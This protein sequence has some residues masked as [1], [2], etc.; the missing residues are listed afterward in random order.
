[1]KK[2]FILFASLTLG[3]LVASCQN[4]LE[5]VINESAVQDELASTR[6]DEDSSDDEEIP[7]R[8]P[9]GPAISGPKIITGTN[10]YIYSVDRPSINDTILW[11]Y[12]TSYFNRII[13]DTIPDTT[14]RLTLKN[15]NIA[16]DATIIANFHS[17]GTYISHQSR[18][19]IGINGP[20]YNHCSIRVVR[21]SDGAEIYP[22][23]TVYMEPNTNY[24]A[25]FS[26]TTGGSNMNL[27]WTFYDND[28]DVDILNQYGYTLFFKTGDIDNCFL[29]ID[30]KLYGSNI[31]KSLLGIVLY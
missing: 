17:S 5:E 6:A 26:T 15:A 24:Y 3:L 18:Y 29:H 30:G 7:L 16:A 2:T 10:E 4:G 1:M 12:N 13:N 8:Y 9:I 25:Y 21:S 31:T 11:N 27:T 19:D 20:H 23:H 22:N 28:D 14:L